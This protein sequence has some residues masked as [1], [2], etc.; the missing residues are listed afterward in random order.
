[1]TPPTKKLRV[2]T[3]QLRKKL[4]ELS[5]PALRKTKPKVKPNTEIP[6]IPSQPQTQIQPADSGDNVQPL[7][8]SKRKFQPSGLSRLPRQIFL[9]ILRSFPSF[10][11]ITEITGLVV[12]IYLGLIHLVTPA[13]NETRFASCQGKLSGQ[14][15]T[16]WG[17]LN[18]QEDH[19]G[20]IRGKFEYRHVDK[21]LVKGELTGRLE[22]QAVNFD[23]QEVQANKS[24]ARGQGV[25]VFTTDC[26]EFFG[27]TP[28]LGAWQGKRITPT[29]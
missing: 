3:L 16:R 1:M 7:P 23:W 28:T 17:L 22:A 12:V 8:T 21:G 29:P 4:E 18:L 9:Q 10:L 2:S 26:L 6:K 25:F 19:Q 15:Q 5:A 11:L 27:S 20:I 24:T 14:W 13:T